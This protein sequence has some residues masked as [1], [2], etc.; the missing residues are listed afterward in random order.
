MT[1]IYKHS[2]VCILF[3]KKRQRREKKWVNIFLINHFISHVSDHCYRLP[4]DSDKW[5]REKKKTAKFTPETSFGLAKNYPRKDNRPILPFFQMRNVLIAC[6][7]IN[8]WIRRI[9]VK[10]REDLYNTHQ[11][12]TYLV[13]LLESFI[14]SN[15]TDIISNGK[16]T[17]TN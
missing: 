7:F 3:E 14:K 13:F 9:I 16:T 8:R 10:V 6:V 12:A 17:I 2:F 1:C 4:S 15:W 5:R 11:H